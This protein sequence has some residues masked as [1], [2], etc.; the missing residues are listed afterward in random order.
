MLLVYNRDRFNNNI[1]KLSVDSLHGL[2]LQDASSY[3]AKYLNLGKS[4]GDE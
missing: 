1:W 2:I 3:H 4:Q